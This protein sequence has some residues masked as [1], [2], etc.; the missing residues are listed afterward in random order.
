MAAG[1]QWKG[2]SEKRIIRPVYVCVKLVEME[3]KKIS[4]DFVKY[5]QKSRTLRHFSGFFKLLRFSQ[6]L[7]LT[8]TNSKNNVF[9]D[10]T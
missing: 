6:P 1:E 2:W 9:I 8:N 10:E 7:K 5:R 3:I 4:C